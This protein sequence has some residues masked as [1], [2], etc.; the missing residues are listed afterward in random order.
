MQD[1]PVVCVELKIGG[2]VILDRALDNVDRFTRRDACSIPKTKDMRVHSLC[3]L[4]PPHV[5]DHIGGFAPHTGQA[6]ECCATIGHFATVN[7][8]KDLAQLHHVLGFLAE[9][10]DGFDMICQPVKTQIEQLLGG[11]RDL[12]KRPCRL[13]DACVSCLC[14]KRDCHD[15]RVYVHVFQL[16]FRGWIRFL[17]TRENCAYCMVVKLLGHG[18][19]YAVFRKNEQARFHISLGGLLNEYLPICAKK[20]L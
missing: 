6:L 3:R 15:Q 16:S 8:H 2:D 9:K 5:Q 18:R 7:I 20:A 14:T 13:V 10:A 11:V 12:E 4:L 1:H 17:K 19:L